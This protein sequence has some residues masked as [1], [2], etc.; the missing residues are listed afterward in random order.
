MSDKFNSFWRK[1]FYLLKPLLPRAV[2]IFLRR[3]IVIRKRQ[4]Y[5]H[6]WPISDS[7]AKP[8]NF[9]PGWPQGKKFAVVLTH[10]VETAFGQERCLALA[11]LES[12]L[13]FRSSFNFVPERYPVQEKIRNQLTQN[14]FEV[15][16]H[17]LY[18]DGKLYQSRKTFM[19]RAE[20]INHYLKAWNA[21]GFRSP[22]MHHNLEWLHQLDI[23]YD[24]STFDT[25][26]FEPQS[27]GVD[28]IFP[29]WVENNGSSRGY[30][31]LPYTLVQDF[32]QFIL[33]REKNNQLW[34]QKADWIAEKG[35]MI[36]LNTHPDYMNFDGKHFTISE[37]PVQYY[38]DFLNYVNDKYN[39]QYWHVL[40]NKIGHY[41]K[42]LYKK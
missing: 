17:G 34:Q 27:D 28:T 25:D 30:V 3:Q 1:I 15:G 32:T 13:G 29:F 5:A 4:Q 10:D 41:W 38:K 8:K 35:G 37:Y 20:K 7:S 9:W 33:M 18:H 39:E 36:L 16:V 40:P 22:A 26:P 23:I 31:E 24:A 11:E 6:C 12:K 21:V 19:Q 14:G 2:Q 42:Y